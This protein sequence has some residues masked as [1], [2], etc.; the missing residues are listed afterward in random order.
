MFLDLINFYRWK[1]FVYK[2][3]E[4]IYIYTYDSDVNVAKKKK[5]I[6]NGRESQLAIYDC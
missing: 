5:F 2:P 6:L 4:F 3:N 1:F